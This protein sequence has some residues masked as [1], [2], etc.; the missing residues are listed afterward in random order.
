MFRSPYFELLG[1]PFENLC[2]A[3]LKT[4]LLRD[5]THDS[6]KR[7]NQLVLFEN[8]KIQF[9]NLSALYEAAGDDKS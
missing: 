9:E 5:R 2:Q 4:K 8:G 7:K 6:I 1:I 3:R